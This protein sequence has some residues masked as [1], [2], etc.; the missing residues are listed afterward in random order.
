MVLS[1]LKKGEKAQIVRINSCPIFY[2][3]LASMG[4]FEGSSI[5]I[6]SGSRVGP[7]LFES[8]GKS[9]ALGREI[10]EQI[11]IIKQ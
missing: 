5:S 6:V 2:N 8:D 3:R 7:F 9:F 4:I 1:S 10:A 11:E